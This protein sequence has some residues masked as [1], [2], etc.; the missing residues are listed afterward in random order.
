MNI[1]LLTTSSGGGAE[2]V[3]DKVEEFKFEIKQ[4]IEACVRIELGYECEHMLTR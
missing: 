2:S 3:Q 4:R 1:Q